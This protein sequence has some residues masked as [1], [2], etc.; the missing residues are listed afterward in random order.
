LQGA[1]D[2]FLADDVG[3]FLRPVFARQDLV[4]HRNH[5]LYS[6]AGVRTARAWNLAWSMGSSVETRLAASPVAEQDGASPVSTG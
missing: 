3:E 1:G 4:A 5:R 2:V 6:F